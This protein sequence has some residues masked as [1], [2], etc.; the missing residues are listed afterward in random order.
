MEIDPTTARTGFTLIE[1]LVVIAI[2]GVLIAL[3][4]PAVQGAREAAR[5][6][7]C[8]NNLKQL[9][10][11]M[12]N[13]EGSFGVFPAAMHGSVGAVYGNFTG[14]HSLLPYVEQ[15]PLF[16]TFNV[17]MSLYA[18]GFGHYYG[19]SVDAQSTGHAIQ[20]GLFLCPSNR[21]NGELGM[22]SGGWTIPRGAVT[23]YVFSGGADNYVSRPFLNASRRGLSGIDV[24]T[25]ISEVRDGFS[26]SFMIGEAV[27]GDQSNPFI[28]SGFAGNRVCVPRE[29]YADAKHYD[30]FMFMA[31]GRR[32]NWGTEYIVGGLIGK[33]TDRIGAYYRLNDCG[34]ASATD[35]F[36]GAPLPTEG[37][38]LPNFRSVHPGGANFL[39]GDGSVRFVKNS[40][41][42]VVYTNLSTI[43]GNEAVSA[44]S[45]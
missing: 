42:R 12:A 15:T 36:S 26:G 37:Q 45:Y 2:I 31:Y 4:L 35:Y 7:Q 5:R 17:N 40:T 9:G 13:Y 11:A 34:Y 14:Y 43:A 27:G 30:N 32:R 28:A 8:V 33:T 16:D 25:R 22:T 3:L 41:D 20:V 38:T 24:F 1:L 19:W 10:L 44:D 18:P 21:A 6:A 39:F 29:Q 23:D